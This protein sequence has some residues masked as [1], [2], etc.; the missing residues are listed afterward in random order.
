MHADSGLHHQAGCNRIRPQQFIDP[1]EHDATGLFL[2]RGFKG[3]RPVCQTHSRGVQ[4]TGATAH[5]VTADLDEGP[6]IEQ[7]VQRVGCTPQ[8][9]D[10]TNAGRGVEHRSPMNGAQGAA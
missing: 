5:C 4:Q 8:A 6:I 3:A 1:R 9:D 10:F 2:L 7:N